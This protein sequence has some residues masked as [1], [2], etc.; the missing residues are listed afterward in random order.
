MKKSLIS[1]N[2]WYI[3]GEQTIAVTGKFRNQQNSVEILEHMWNITRCIL[4]GCTD[5]G[6]NYLTFSGLL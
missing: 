5:N 3:S 2:V 4:Q 1:I 6:H